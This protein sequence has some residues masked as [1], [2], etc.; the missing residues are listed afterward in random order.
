MY[1]NTTGRPLPDVCVV[2]GTANCGPTAPHTD[3][4]G[5][6]SA[7]VAASSNSTL[8]D[9]YFIKTGYQRQFRQITLPGGVS[10]TYIIFMRRG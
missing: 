8:W 2:I 9:L 10:R 4:S 6:W 1:D 3:A 5:R 7:D